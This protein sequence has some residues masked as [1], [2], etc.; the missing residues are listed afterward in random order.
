MKKLLLV[1]G[2][3]LSL[4]TPV[5][6]YGSVEDIIFE[7]QIARSRLCFLG[8]FTLGFCVNFVSDDESRIFNNG[9]SGA[10]ALCG[11]YIG[12]RT[13]DMVFYHDQ[14]R[15]VPVSDAG[16]PYDLFMHTL[17]AGTGYAGGSIL[18]IL[19]RSA[20]NKAYASIAA[21]FQKKE[22]VPV[23]MPVS[24]PVS[25]KLEEEAVVQEN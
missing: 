11:N 4:Q 12:K 25:E 18:G 17:L 5:A 7:S 9:I 8:N 23:P 6:A 2:L 1:L 14:Q 20:V 24:E 19:S 15:M 16:L 21:L 3:I 13:S 22:Q 10:F